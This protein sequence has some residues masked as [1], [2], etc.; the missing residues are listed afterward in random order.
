MLWPSQS[1]DLNLIINLC[2]ELKKREHQREPG[3]LDE[4]KRGMVSDDVLCILQP[5]K[6]F[7]F[8][9]RQNYKILNAGVPIHV[10]LL[11]NNLRDLCFSEKNVF[12]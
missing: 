11:K 12:E 1:P 5:H 3:T 9:L 6:S 10:F 8:F 4:L 2:D 7:V